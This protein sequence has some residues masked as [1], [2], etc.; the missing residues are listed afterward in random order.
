MIYEN[1]ECIEKYLEKYANQKPDRTAVIVKDSYTSYEQLWKLVCGFA[2]FLKEECQVD[3]GDRVV[4]KVKQTLDLVVTYFAIHLCEATFVPL[5]ENIT[6]D[7]ALRIIGETQAKIYISKDYLCS[8]GVKWINLDKVVKIATSWHE[9]SWN[10]GFP[11]LKSTA[12]IMYTTG[13]TG[14]PK[15]V[16]VTHQTLI[17]TAQ[18]YI[19]GFELEDARTAGGGYT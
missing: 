10:Q 15:G 2:S 6:G 14:R 12:D 11:N 1:F 3:R 8:S 7:K 4:V 5:E 18:N 17:A 16:E 9:N 19:S 13:T